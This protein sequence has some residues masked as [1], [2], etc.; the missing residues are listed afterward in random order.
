MIRL[1]SETFAEVFGLVS[2][3][4]LV[5]GL[6]HNLNGPLQN[7]GMDMDMIRFS[8]QNGQGPSPALIE[9]I[10]TRIR[11]M[12]DEFEQINRLIRACASRVTEDDEE[13]YLTLADFLDQ[14]ITFLKTN[15]YFKH[16]VKSE[17]L[18]ENDL[19]RLG[20]LAEGVSSGLRS[21]LY[22]VAEDME[23]RKMD[24]FS[25]KARACGSGIEVQLTAGR[26]PL[27]G[28]FLEAVHHLSAD[29]DTGEVSLEQAA[30]VQAFIKLTQAGVGFEV[31]EETGGGTGITLTLETR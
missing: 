12:G 3:G 2:A 20:T 25:L 14:E 4:K 5:Q 24:S 23:R 9:E 11:R 27:S 15:L 18:L 28:A 10:E 17:I 21:L 26:G 29:D 31:A 16:N 19:P 1:S 30:A 8:L 7:L 6:I 13:G 22:A